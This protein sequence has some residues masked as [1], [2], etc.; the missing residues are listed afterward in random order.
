MPPNG[1]GKDKTPKTPEV[2]VTTQLLDG[3]GNSGYDPDEVTTACV[4]PASDRCLSV[5]SMSRVTSLMK[6]RF[7]LNIYKYVAHLERG[8]RALHTSTQYWMQDSNNLL[9]VNCRYP[10][11]SPIPGRIHSVT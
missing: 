10:Y 6:R 9:L 4:C 11:T 5:L 3:T 1:K 7:I 8:K 2:G